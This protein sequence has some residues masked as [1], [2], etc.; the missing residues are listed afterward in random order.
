MSKQPGGV[1]GPADVLMVMSYVV[2][3][4]GIAG[5]AFLI[6]NGYFLLGIVVLLAGVFFFA[7]GLTL[8]TMAH[9]TPVRAPRKTREKLKL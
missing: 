7:L 8:A 1:Q 2:L 5:M 4:G 3:V 6:A 9:N